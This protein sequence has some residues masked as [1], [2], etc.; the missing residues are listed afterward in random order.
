MH[1]PAQASAWTPARATVVLGLFAV[2]IFLN[3]T[4]LFVVQPMFTK[5]VLP[6]LGGTSAVWNTCLMFFQAALLVGYLY[7]HLTSRRFSARTQGLVHLGVMLVALLTLPLVVRGANT[8]ASGASAPIL[9]LLG[10]LSISLGLPFV[11]LAA[12]AP[13]FQRWLASTAHPAAANPYVLYIASNLGSFVALLAYPTLIEPRLTLS[14]QRTWWTVIYVV[15]L[16]LVGVALWLTVRLVREK[17]ATARREVAEPQPVDAAAAAEGAPLVATSDADTPRRPTIVPTRAWRIRWVLL[18]FA[19]SSLLVGVTTYLST[20]V[21]AIPL[22][23]VVPLALY[24]LTFVLVFAERPLLNRTFMLV[25]QLFVGLGLLVTIGMAPLKVQLA[26]LVFHLLAFFVTAMMCHRELADSRPRPEYLTEFYLWMSVGGLLGGVF[27]VVIAPLIYDRVLEYPLALIIAFGLRPTRVTPDNSLRAVALDLG[28]PL[29]LYGAL[30]AAFTIQVPSGR[31]GTVAMVTLFIIVSLIIA[32]FHKRPLRL[33]LAAAA[34]FLAVDARGDTD[35]VV[36]Q[37]RSFFG[38]Y[39]VRKWGD[40]LVLQ[41]GTTT[42]GAQSLTPE[43]QR[44]PLTY[45]ARIGPL[46]DAFD[47]LTD[48]TAVRNVALVGL[49]SGTTACYARPFEIWTYYEIDPAVVRMATSGRLFTYLKLCGPNHRVQLGDA[50]VSLQ[51]AKDSSFD[52]IALDAFSSDAIPVHLM[53]REALQL[54]LRKLKPNGSILFH[55]SNRY[56]EL[57][58]VVQQLA[59]DAHLASAARDFNPNDDEKARMLYGSRWVALARE[60]TI[61]APLVVERSWRLLDEKPQNLLWTDDYSN[62][63]G[64]LKREE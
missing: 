21:A 23:W 46:G 38:V 47:I 10:I 34:M 57:E 56:L 62:V 48:S 49:G 5:M 25:F 11:L 50:R 45:Y 52:L 33:A 64:V 30:L 55:I 20:D 14:E 63:V 43:L 3:A 22:L 44:E 54:Y 2:L 42:H 8:A 17:E 40:F 4:L 51:A 12:G 28:F 35:D 37:E 18:S 24:L 27:N 19:P 58:P 53:T 41:H 32:S 36:H 16:G 7:A 26:S 15:L 29:A 31:M 59:R 6:L 60:S 1:R 61:L 13:M 9:W 39:R